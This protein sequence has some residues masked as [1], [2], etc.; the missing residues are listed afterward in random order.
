MKGCKGL[1]DRIPDDRPFGNAYKTHALCRRCDKWLRK[2]YLIDFNCPCC[3][4]R[5]KMASRKSNR[6]DA[7]RLD[8]KAM[9]VV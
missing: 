8:V 3:K 1:C 9:H 2:T 4:R 5:P 6:D 7:V